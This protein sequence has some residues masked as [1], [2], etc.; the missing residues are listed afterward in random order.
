MYKNK[1]V[2]SAYSKFTIIRQNLLIFTFFLILVFCLRFPSFL[3]SVINWDESLYL[4]MADAMK[5]GHL[6]YTVIWD[7]KPPGIYIL[8]FLS[9]AIFGDSIISIRIAACI[10]IA[11]TCYLLYC[12]GHLINRNNPRAGL[13]A[14]LLYALFSLSNGG[15]ASNTELFLAPFT[16]LAFLI[17][18]FTIPN[19]HNSSSINSRLVLLIGILLGI[20]IQIKQVAIF[21]F[22]AILTIISIHLYFAITNIKN[23]LMSLFKYF[24][25][26]EIGFL[27]PAI[28]FIVY[29]YLNGHLED[30]WYANFSANLLRISG[31]DFKFFRI[32]QAV[33]NNLFLWLFFSIA[34]F[35]L[36]FIQARSRQSKALL[37]YLVVWLFFS[38]IG[39]YIG[40][41]F[42][43]HYF[44]TLLPSLC[45]ISSFVITKIISFTKAMK[46]VVKVLVFGAIATGFLL[47]FINI[48]YLPYKVGLTNLYNRYLL[49]KDNWGDRS[50]KIAAYL[51]KKVDL[52][53][54]IYV[55]NDQP[56]IYYLVGSKIPTKYAF[57]FFL[58]SDLSKIAGVN[59]V[60]EL[61]S[62]FSKEPTY[63]ILKKGGQTN[64]LFYKRLKENLNNQ[65]KLEK[66]IEGTDLYK[67]IN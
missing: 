26:I 60:D 14:A 25:I 36:V 43:L 9:L 50:A 63:I 12:F 38:C 46:M 44:L 32:Q 58:I 29:F 62:I 53:D 47:S 40:K 31:G 37:T 33:N 13:I 5:N 7:N 18:L 22:A 30:F 67:R 2:L 10:A 55:V 11:T 15:L 45:L 16:T 59:P 6:P 27:V 1:R 20:S 34:I 48:T 41:E 19:F 35:Y 54:Y 21:G 42:Y 57:P 52:K 3:Q 56:I 4:L 17:L 64:S 61:N 23:Y 28:I 49:G 8:F 24:F 65:Y 66:T 51:E 39:V